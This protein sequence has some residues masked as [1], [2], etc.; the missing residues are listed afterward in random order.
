MPVNKIV[1]AQYISQLIAEKLTLDVS[2]IRPKQPLFAIGVSS[3]ISE[4][5]LASLGKSYDRLS[6]TF[7]FEYPT[8]DKISAYSR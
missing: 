2:Q 8:V 5:I 7:L 4:E 3:L 1:I 6:S